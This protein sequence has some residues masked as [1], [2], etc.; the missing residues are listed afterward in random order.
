M[1]GAYITKHR[2]Q[3]YLQSSPSSVTLTRALNSQT[4]ITLTL[5][6]PLTRCSGPNAAA[7]LLH[8]ATCHRPSFYPMQV[9]S[10]SCTGAGAA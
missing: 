1:R 7:L 4:D 6:L 3:L 5:P 9:P 8:S 10:R 2:D